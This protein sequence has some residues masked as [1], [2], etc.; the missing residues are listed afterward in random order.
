VRKVVSLK[1]CVRGSWLAVAVVGAAAV[2]CAIDE[3]ID[4]VDEEA[5]EQSLLEPNVPTT[6][7]LEIRAQLCK[8][9]DLAPPCRLFWSDDLNLVNDVWS[10]GS[11]IGTMA[12]S[13][14]VAA[15]YRVTVCDGG[16]FGGSCRTYYG[17]KVGQ[18]VNLAGVLARVWS[19]EVKPVAAPWYTHFNP[20]NQ[21]EIG[22][23]QV[24]PRDSEL[25][26][27]ESEEMQG[28]AHDPIGNYW[29]L[30]SR[31]QLA[32]VPVSADLRAPSSLITASRF[33]GDHFGDPDFDVASGRLYVPNYDGPMGFMEI[34]DRNLTYLGYVLGPYGGAG[35]VAINPLNGLLYTS[36]SLFQLDV[37]DPNVPYAKNMNYLY[38]ISL[39]RSAYKAA[40]GIYDDGWWNE[41]DK[42]VQGGAF[43]TN[44]EFYFVVDHGNDD[45]SV[46]TGVYTFQL[47]ARTSKLLKFVNIKYPAGLFGSRRGELE[48]ITIWDLDAVSGRH[49]MVANK[50]HVVRLNNEAED[51]D[52]SLYH[53]PAKRSPLSLVRVWEHD[54][55]QGKSDYFYLE[56][57]QAGVLYNLHNFNGYPLTIADRGSS[58]SWTSVAGNRCRLVFYERSD[59]T[60]QP[61]ST[62]YSAGSYSDLRTVSF[63]DKMSSMR[64]FCY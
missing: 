13:L 18:T 29:Y 21:D 63:G 10:D 37:Y 28:V 33:Q 8:Y 54:T 31:G 5:V 43:D 42:W 58:M 24:Y 34:Y 2:S 47:D 23:K 17:G 64:K 48:G 55:F 49:P 51:D 26:A 62:G 20:T 14:F 16:N 61:L 46:A 9:A 52:V 30:A 11:T 50:I 60:G 57:L 56:E 4:G 25:G 45:N 32:K 6:P 44:G 22:L 40:S 12:R 39:P 19:I 3:S 36:R 41:A 35:W 53:I 59:G 15:G 7:P 38:S 1:R 27:V